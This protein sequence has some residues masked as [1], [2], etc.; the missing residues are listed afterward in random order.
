MREAAKK[1]MAKARREKRESPP[2]VPGALAMALPW[3]KQVPF[4]EP[5]A[6]KALREKM[7]QELTWSRMVK[8]EAEAKKGLG[9]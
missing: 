4:L 6:A 2:K 9:G 3:K 5:A 1:Q 7:Q 8:A